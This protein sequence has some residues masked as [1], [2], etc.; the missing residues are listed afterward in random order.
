MRST[1]VIVFIIL[2]VALGA[3]FSIQ[4]SSGA[5]ITANTTSILL[6][7]VG[8]PSGTQNSPTY[9]LDSTPVYTIFYTAYSYYGKP[10]ISNVKGT[11]LIN[12]SV[13]HPEIKTFFVLANP[14][15]NLYQVAIE[16]IYNYNS[17]V[18]NITSFTFTV[19]MTVKGYISKTYFPTTT[20]YYG[21][22]TGYGVVQTIENLGQFYI[23]DFQPY[24]KVSTQALQ[25]ISTS[26]EIQLN[27]SS[28]LTSV[29]IYYITDNN[30]T[31]MSN[32]YITINGRN[33]YIYKNYELL[34]ETHINNLIAGYV[35][36]T[37]LSGLYAINGYLTPILNNTPTEVI[38]FGLDLPYLSS[39]LI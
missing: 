11:L 31:P 30:T 36:I 3:L 21:Q 32:L 9:F 38:S 16:S 39:M 13:I 25:Q 35:T 8:N 12:K 1:V 26:S 10:M 28:S 33:Y 7:Q 14:N 34:N 5:L 23:S 17:Q 2:A 18:S 19:S 27:V 22:F 29:T 37:L 4:T 15:L 6:Y 24:T 20:T